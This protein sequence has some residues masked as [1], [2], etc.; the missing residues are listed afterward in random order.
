MIR[1][2]ETLKL[3]NVLLLAALA[4]GISFSCAPAFGQ[5]TKPPQKQNDA[6]F[7]PP[8][9]MKPENPASNDTKSHD[10]K[11]TAANR[12]A[13]LSLTKIEI[14]PASISLI[15]RHSSQRLLVEGTFADGHEEDVT[16]QV[17]L[18]VTDTKV[19]I[20]DKDNS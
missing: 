7:H 15:G 20:I 14:V 8:E 13:L 6:P 5:S 18:S 10:A 9:M 16:S 4:A 2:Y 11:S 17:K 3:P 19:A 12:Q 1:I